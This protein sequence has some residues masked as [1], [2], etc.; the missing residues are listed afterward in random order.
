MAT[1]LEPIKIDNAVAQPEL[2]LNCSTV[3]AGKYC[4]NCG[5]K[6]FQHHDFALKHF[7]GHVVHEFTHLDS[8]KIIKTL[9]SLLFRPGLLTDEYLAGRKGHYINP[10]RVYL[11]ISFLYFLFGWGPLLQAG[12]G[13]AKDLVSQEWFVTIAKQRGIEP[14]SLAERIDQKREK[15]VSGMRF[16]GV[17]LSGAFLTFLYYGKR[18]YYVE[19]LIFSL[20]FYSFDFFMRCALAVSFVGFS[21]IGLLFI[22]PVRVFFYLIIFIYILLAVRRVYKESWA[23]TV[24]KSVVL[25]AGETLLFISIVVLGTYIAFSVA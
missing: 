18:K 11:T 13:A 19:H 8:N 21:K 9:L 14:H 16:I 5:Q 2:C 3:L 23:K 7:L 17:L 22:T 10:I 6:R 20:H 4:H 24:S 1:Y 25:F 15:Y 12:G